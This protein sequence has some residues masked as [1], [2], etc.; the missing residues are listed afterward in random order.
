MGFGESHRQA[1]MGFIPGERRLRTA[2]PVNGGTS[3]GRACLALTGV[4][5]T[6]TQRWSTQDSG[7]NRALTP[8]LGP[9]T[10]GWSP[11]G[12]VKC[13]WC[14]GARSPASGGTL[15]LA[16]HQERRQQTGVAYGTRTVSL[17][18]LQSC[19]KSLMSPKP[20]PTRHEHLVSGSGFWH[21]D[22]YIRNY[23]HSVP[24][25]SVGLPDACTRKL[26]KH[27]GSPIRLDDR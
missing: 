18:P 11:T 16:T 26:C 12:P 8:P 27:Q 7:E 3:L 25:S 22:Q 14:L 6:G 15:E 13:P 17:K 1:S 23:F 2:G 5:L 21:V 10:P 9:G 4:T 24:M 20:R 19:P